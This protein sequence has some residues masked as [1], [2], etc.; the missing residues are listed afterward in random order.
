MSAVLIVLTKIS[1]QGE[2]LAMQILCVTARLFVT[3]VSFIHLVDEL[4][5]FVLLEVDAILGD[6]CRI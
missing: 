1:E 4:L 2:Y 3:R 5:G 6:G